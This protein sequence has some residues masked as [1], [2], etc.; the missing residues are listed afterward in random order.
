MDEDYEPIKFDPNKS[1]HGKR[2]KCLEK[3]G[4]FEGG[5]ILCDCCG[6]S[7][8]P[9][10]FEKHAGSAQKRPYTSIVIEEGNLTLTEYRLTFEPRRKKLASK[11]T[12]NHDN[13]SPTTEPK[14]KKESTKPYKPYLFSSTNQP[15]RNSTGERKS[16][17]QQIER[18]PKVER[19]KQ[20]ISEY[21]TKVW[22]PLSDLKVLKN[23]V[24]PELINYL[25]LEEREFLMT[26]L[27][28]TDQKLPMDQLFKL[29]GFQSCL[30][31]WSEMLR[32]GQFDPKRRESLNDRRERGWSSE[33]WKKEYFLNYWGEDLIN[34]RPSACVSQ[35]SYKENE[36]S[37]S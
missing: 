34:R 28:Q 7:F 33:P 27:P 5:K 21:F 4:I 6:E 8:S 16:K 11:R 13:S 15:K 36:E 35:Y 22:S 1:F 10:N 29:E 23:L 3:R 20:E 2:A 25:N 18:K 17:K 32:Q 19:S 14:N 30:Q 37:G 9:T 12:T 24:Q 26:F 31:Y